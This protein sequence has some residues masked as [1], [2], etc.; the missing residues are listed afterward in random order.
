MS[1]IGLKRGGRERTRYFLL[2]ESIADLGQTGAFV[3][4]VV[5]AVGRRPL[6]EATEEFSANWAVRLGLERLR[7]EGIPLASYVDLQFKFRLNFLLMLLEFARQA[8]SRER[9]DTAVLSG[10]FPEEQQVL[11]HAFRSL[12]VKVEVKTRR[13]RGGMDGIPFRLKARLRRISQ[14]S[15]PRYGRYVRRMVRLE[16]APAV[17]EDPRI[18][19]VD[20][21]ALTPEAFRY[22]K[23]RGVLLHVMDN[24]RAIKKILLQAG[25]PFRSIGLKGTPPADWPARD[26]LR[27]PDEGVSWF[28]YRGIPFFPLVEKTVRWAIWNVA[29]RLFSYGSLPGEGLRRI[30]LRDQNFAEGKM[31]VWI[32]RKAGIPTV[33]LQHGPTMGDYGYLP[34]DADV[35]VTWGEETRRWMEERGVERSRLEVIGSPRFDSYTGVVRPVETRRFGKTILLVFESTEYHGEDS[36]LDNYRFLRLVLDAIAPLDGWE[37][38]VRFHP[39]QT[40]EEREACWRVVRPLAPRVRIDHEMSLSKSLDK[41]DVVVTEASTVGMEGLLHGKLLI[42]VPTHR[43]EGNPYRMTDAFPRLRTAEEIRDCLKRWEDSERNRHDAREEAKRFLDGY[44]YRDD[45][46]AS[47]R[48]WKYC[49]GE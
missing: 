46:P 23:G 42:V 44:L 26:E 12:G 48:F 7:I 13:E 15:L 47:V 30:V 49:L 1:Y 45:E 19:V 14:V 3:H 16:V 31:L 27:F 34:M 22:L 43:F 5:D 40:I 4:D 18:L 17:R 20:S 32:A 35:F 38:V 33:M 11:S 36:P 41:V 10:L 37:V 25:V 28:T 29:P 6:I 2:P 8:V 21:Y 24:D 39:G 9:P